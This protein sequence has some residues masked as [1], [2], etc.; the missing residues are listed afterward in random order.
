[1][2][3]CNFGQNAWRHLWAEIVFCGR[4]R[5][6][7]IQRA[8]IHVGAVIMCGKAATECAFTAGRWPVDGD[9]N[10]HALGDSMQSCEKPLDF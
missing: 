3:A 8:G 6:T 2:A 4:E 7:T 9:Y 1:M 10:T 5:H